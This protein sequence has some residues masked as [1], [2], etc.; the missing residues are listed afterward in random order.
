MYSSNLQLKN[1]LTFLPVKLVITCILYLR[2]ICIQ[3]SRPSLS[4]F[5]FPFCLMSKAFSKKVNFML[6]LSLLFSMNVTKFMETCTNVVKVTLI[7]QIAYRYDQT[8]IQLRLS[9]IFDLNFSTT[10]I[11]DAR[12]VG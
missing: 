3:F 1:N 7:L 11:V 2:E 6:M 8:N 10:A 4:F 9:W 12:T 5:N